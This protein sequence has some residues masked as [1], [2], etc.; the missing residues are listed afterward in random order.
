MKNLLKTSAVLLLCVLSCCH[1][2]SDLS[3]NPAPVKVNQS[4]SPKLKGRFLYGNL[5]STICGYLTNTSDS[6]A[7]TPCPNN[8]GGIPTTT[9]ITWASDSLS[10]FDDGYKTNTYLL[11][12][13]NDSIFIRII[14]VGDENDT[15]HQVRRRAFYILK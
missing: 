13:T 3:S 6:S 15:L 9:H 2:K 7:M 8:P 12:Y 5:D 10:Y 1:K 4:S 11:G 14:E